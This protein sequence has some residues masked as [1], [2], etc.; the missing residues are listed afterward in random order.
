MFGWNSSSFSKKYW[1]FA[2]TKILIL[3]S[4]DQIMKQ[5]KVL[6][7]SDNIRPVSRQRDTKPLKRPPG[8]WGPRVPRYLQV[9]SV[10]QTFL[11]LIS[12][13]SEFDY[14]VVNN[15]WGRRCQACDGLTAFV[16][17]FPISSETTQERQ[18]TQSKIKMWAKIN[19]WIIFS[20]QLLRECV[21]VCVWAS[22]A[23]NNIFKSPFSCWNMSP[24]SCTA[25]MINWYNN[26]NSVHFERTRLFIAAG[27]R[28][29]SVSKQKFLDPLWKY[30]ICVFK[31]KQFY[32]EEQFDALLSTF[33]LLW[34]I[35]PVKVIQ[36]QWS[37][38]GASCKSGLQHLAELN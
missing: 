11:N 6:N 21:C 13:T 9:R 23:L 29:P 27:E 31:G 5:S 14:L 35:R 16:D 26:T 4:H 10:I 25:I 15:V 7:L 1:S 3:H 33:Q 24:R 12:H 22:V 19:K 36:G 38:A 20:L 28:T 17:C 37:H 32:A 18:P 8:L 2:K 34:T 30:Q